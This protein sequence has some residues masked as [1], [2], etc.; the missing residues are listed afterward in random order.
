ME[1]AGMR[2]P[3][4]I[5]IATVVLFIGLGATP[6]MA[7]L[8]SFGLK[9]GAN[10]SNFDTENITA[11]SHTGFVGGAFADMII[12]PLHVELLYSQSGFKDATTFNAVDY[13]TRLTTIDVPV[14]FQL[15]LPLVGITPFGYAGLSFA[16]LTK[17]ESKSNLTNDDWEDI[18]AANPDLLWAIPLGIGAQI[19]KFHADLRYTYGL[20]TLKDPVHD[21]EYMTRTWSLMIGWA[22][23]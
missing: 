6:A 4:L 21:Q 23:F 10:F 5:R 7:L 19:A 13:A 8:P 18:T 14:V 12:L 16:F 2:K 1:V 11:S 20:T 9:A 15:K 22:I 17:A 3:P